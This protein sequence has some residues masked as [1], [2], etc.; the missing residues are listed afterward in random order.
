M[1][2]RHLRYFIAVAEELHFTR[3]AERLHIGQPPLSQ[4]IQSLEEELGVRLFDRTRRRVVLT[5]AG[6]HF[7]IGARRVFVEAERAVEE[8]Q[9]AARG[10]IGQLRVGYSASLPFTSFL[11]K[12]LHDY[13]EKY[14][15][16]DL[17]LSGLFS[18]EQ[19]DALLGDRLDIG[20]LRY[21]GRNV[22]AGIELHEISRDS[23]LVVVN[24]NNPLAAQDSVSLI[25][26]KNESFIT[27][28]HDVG[29]RFNEHERQLCLA[30][31]FEPRVAQEAREATTQIGLVAAGFGISLLP[32]PLACVKIEGV[33]YLPLRDQ[34][35]DVLLAAATRTGEHSA[36][37]AGFLE[38]LSHAPGVPVWPDHNFGESSPI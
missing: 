3:A 36:L 22:P 14:P 19:Y 31:G 38:V 12:V 17:K 8:A 23:L 5:E 15:D 1:E 13:C 10:E 33:R 11:P 4:Q 25:D 21:S 9:R 24:S 32:A 2:L 16:V 6:Q 26:L 18:A 28:P 30:A 29:A 20:L 34:G 7:L 35:A 37:I 27:Y